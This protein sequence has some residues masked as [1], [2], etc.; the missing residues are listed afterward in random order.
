VVAIAD[1]TSNMTRADNFAFTAEGSLFGP[2]PYTPTDHYPAYTASVWGWRARPDCM[3]RVASN[4][5]ELLMRLSEP[6]LREL[7]PGIPVVAVFCTSM[8][9]TSIV[10]R[11]SSAFGLRTKSFRTCSVKCGARN[12]WPAAAVY[13][14]RTILFRTKEPSR[15]FELTLDARDYP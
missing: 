2:S 12:L 1:A 6:T 11:C 4:C 8:M 5:T 9:L 14:A 7:S 3:A 15:G 10:C 13:C